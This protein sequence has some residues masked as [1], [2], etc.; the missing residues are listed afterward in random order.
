MKNI[1]SEPLTFSALFNGGV[2]FLVPPYQRSYAWTEKQ[3]EDIWQDMENLREVSSHFTGTLIFKP[4]SE[5][6]S[7][8]IVDGQ[9][10]LTTLVISFCLCLPVSAQAGRF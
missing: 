3:L 8:E 9:Q 2:K 4:S 7:F 1:S 5:P 6:G 10:R